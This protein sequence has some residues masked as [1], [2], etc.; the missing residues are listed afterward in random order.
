MA[1][2]LGEHVGEQADDT[3]QAAVP[4]RC[5]SGVHASMTRL[6]TP[7]VTIPRVETE[8]GLHHQRQ[9]HAESGKPE[10]QPRQ[11]RRPPYPG[12]SHAGRQ[13]VC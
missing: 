10:I 1:V 12:A 3:A 8:P 2:S 6:P 9:A 11:A 4:A 13:P 7:M 5:L